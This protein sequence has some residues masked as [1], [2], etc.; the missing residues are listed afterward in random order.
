[1]NQS[2]H[3]PTLEYLKFGNIFSSSADDFNFKIFPNVDDSKIR[4]VIW[5][6]RNCLEVSEILFEKVFDLLDGGFNEA[7]DW[8]SNSYENFE[9]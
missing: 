4:V 5:K 9:C 2:L 8:I 7:L 6:G 1:M 3:F